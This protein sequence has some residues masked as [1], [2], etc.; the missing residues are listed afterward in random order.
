MQHD[1][2]H[3][4]TPE[5]KKSEAPP[6]RTPSLEMA[7]AAGNAA[8][9]RMARATSVPRGVAPSPVLARQAHE[10]GEEGAEGA[11]AAP[12]E[13]AHAEEEGPEE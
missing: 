2:E 3:E 6:E 4:Q 8:V 5:A 11:E 13:A 12:E 10:H 1:F 9:Q 7:S